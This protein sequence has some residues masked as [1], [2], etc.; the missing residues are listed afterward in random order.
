M[1]KKR[2]HI[3]FFAG[4][5]GLAIGMEN[6]GFDLEFANELSPMAA[7]TFAFNVL[8][9]D[10]VEK[11][12]K[13]KWIHSKYNSENFEQRLREDTLSHSKVEN[14]DLDFENDKNLNSIKGSLLIGDIKKLNLQLN[15][16]K[17]N[18]PYEGNL[19]LVSGGP[20]CQSFSLAGRRERQNEKNSLPLDYAEVCEKLNPKVVLL[21]N[22]KGILSP[23]TENGNKYYAWLEVAKTFAIKGY[24]PLCMLIN[25]KYFGVAQNRPRFIML[26]LRKDVFNKL[27]SQEIGSDILSNLED[28]YKK[29]NQNKSIS[30]EDLNYYD[31]DKVN[32][33]FDGVILPK[34]TT[35]MRDKWISVMDAINDLSSNDTPSIYVNRINKQFKSAKKLKDKLK[36]HNNRKHSDKVQLRFSFLQYLN[37]C[38]N[39]KNDLIKALKSNKI[40]NKSNHIVINSFLEIK[41][42]QIEDSKINSIEK[43]VELINKIEIT[44]KHSQRALKRNQPSPAQLTS[45]DDLCHY[46]FDLPR[47]LTVR[48]VARIQSFPDWFEF[49]SKETTG[50]INRR[51][52]VPQYTQVGNAVPPLLAYHLGKHINQLLIRISL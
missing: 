41:T 4:C 38:P 29:V 22:V 6:A 43:W 12:S 11:S 2:L 32:Y 45:P 30:I 42:A 35:F 49:K 20:P 23:F 27:K 51:F 34:P 19:D 15:Q 47:A 40:L 37:Y 10:I 46:S 7:N 26:G 44:Q 8:D 9:I 52:E 18:D 14:T 5:G 36:N 21:E 24:Y 50:G 48:E 28:F 33:L 17:I 13:I 3:E 1:N 25:S 39:S 16:A 31:I